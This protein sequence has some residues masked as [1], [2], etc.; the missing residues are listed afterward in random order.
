MLKSGGKKQMEEEQSKEISYNESTY[1][2]GF[3]G[4]PFYR[5]EMRIVL[6]EKKSSV[7]LAKSDRSE[8]S[9]L[10]GVKT[11]FYLRALWKRKF[12]VGLERNDRSE[13][14]ILLGVKGSFCPSKMSTFH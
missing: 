5:L 3:Q 10:L 13:D 1:L 8:D 12:L 9:I 7:G 2:G 11:S 14:S 4:T 6:E